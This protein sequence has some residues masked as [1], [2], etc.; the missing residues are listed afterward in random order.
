MLTMALEALSA[1]RWPVW[2][3]AGNH[4]YYGD[5]VPRPDCG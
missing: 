4:D 5:P 1:L 3:T 2:V